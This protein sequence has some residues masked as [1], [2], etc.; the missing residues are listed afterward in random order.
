MKIRRGQLG[1]V[2]HQRR[3]QRRKRTARPCHG[4]SVRVRWYQLC[5]WAVRWSQS[6]QATGERHVRRRIVTAPA[7]G[8]MASSVRLA[9]SGLRVRVVMGPDL[10]EERGSG[11]VFSHLCVHQKLGR[12]PIM[13]RGL[14]CCA[15]SFCWH[16]AHAL[17]DVGRPP[18]IVP[19]DP[20]IPVEAS[21]TGRGENPARPDL[22][23]SLAT[24]A[25]LADPMDLAATLV[26]GLVER[27]PTSRTPSP[28]RCA[29]P[30]LSAAVL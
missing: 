26:A 5:S 3:V 21:S 9:G 19:T 1:L 29:G 13:W 18:A 7:S 11:R 4:R 25:R 28:P 6:G 10:Y 15:F 8:Y 22:A 23:S 27:T 16:A 14:V 12:P 17:I 2:Q 20:G 30:R 24:G